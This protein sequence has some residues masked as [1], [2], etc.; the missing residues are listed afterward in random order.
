MRWGGGASGRGGWGEAGER[1]E[2]GGPT[3]VSLGVCPCSHRLEGEGLHVH[4]RPSP[5]SGVVS[6]VAGVTH[7]PPPRTLKSHIPSSS[8]PHLLIGQVSG[9]LLGP[10]TGQVRM[11]AAGEGPPPAF[12]FPGSPSPAAG[13]AGDPQSSGL[14]KGLLERDSYGLKR[15]AA[16]LVQLQRLFYRFLKRGPVA[17]RLL[18]TRSAHLGEGVWGAADLSPE[19]AQLQSF[20]ET[21]LSRGERPPL[22]LAG[23]PPALDQE[24]VKVTRASQQDVWGMPWEA[25][26]CVAPGASG[27]P[28]K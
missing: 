17:P 9:Q 25:P 21:A 11:G 20:L 23:C 15:R 24:G 12:Y 4:R 2:V 8:Q 19:Q 1:P 14:S 13:K 16:F 6:H 26:G 28:Q 3:L 10:V 5:L 27:A 22:P 7:A 18:L